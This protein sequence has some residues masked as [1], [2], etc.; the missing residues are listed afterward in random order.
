[1]KLYT[2][3]KY[4]CSS[5]SFKD[6][7]RIIKDAGFDA[8]DM[9]L[10]S[11]YSDPENCVFCKDDYIKEAMELRKYADML[12]IVCNQAHAP[13][14]WRL[15]DADREK[16]LD[17]AVI[18]AIEVAAVLGADII[19]VHPKQYMVYAEHAQELFDINMEYYK[20]LIPYAK[21]YNI[22]IAVENMWQSYNGSH[23]PADSVCSRAFEF[24]KYLDSINSK[25]IVGCL[26]I[27]HAALMGTDIPGF[28][29]AM[30]NKRLKALHVQDNDFV[31]DC[32][33]LPFMEKIDYLAVAKALGAIGYNGDFTYEAFNFYCGKPKELYPATA[34]YMCEVGRFLIAEIKKAALCN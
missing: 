17:A 29:K 23:T 14:E 1:M 25:W 18:R 27:G 21:K 16:K 28:I 30:G 7:I 24:C 5:L 11:I 26:D 34:K 22:R 31:T 8:Y 6:S 9:W 4:L 3:N 20:S 19:V 2:T 33:T 13:N 15:F 10:G 32:H 12:G